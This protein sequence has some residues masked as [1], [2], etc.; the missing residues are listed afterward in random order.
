MR[1]FILAALLI[2]LPNLSFAQNIGAQVDQL[3]RD[4]RRDRRVE[5]EQR[6]FKKPRT[7]IQRESDVQIR[8]APTPTISRSR[9]QTR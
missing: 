4:I 3:E 7:E 9:R 8:T 5:E 6:K 2:L 1:K